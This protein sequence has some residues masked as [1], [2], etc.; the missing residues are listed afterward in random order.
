MAPPDRWSVPH[1][2]VVWCR[3]QTSSRTTHV[4]YTGS[5]SVPHDTYWWTLVHPFTSEWSNETNVYN[6]EVAPL[7][8]VRRILTELAENR[9]V[10]AVGTWT[11]ESAGWSTRRQ[12]YEVW[13]IPNIKQ[14]ERH[15]WRGPV[16]DRRGAGGCKSRG[17]GGGGEQV[18]RDCVVSTLYTVQ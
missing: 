10:R 6:L 16:R 14:K 8:L 7:S 1:W 12:D 15:A 4:S 5:T 18:P 13:T 11:R 9:V 2:P 17:V 3:H